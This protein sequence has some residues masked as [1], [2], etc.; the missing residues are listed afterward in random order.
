M[1]N[2]R[3]FLKQMTAATWLSSV[4]AHGGAPAVLGSSPAAKR[5]KARRRKRPVLWN[6]DGSDMLQPAYAGGKWPNPLKS[7]GKF[8]ANTLSYVKGTEVASIFYCAHVNEPDWEFPQEHIEVLGPNP[9]RHAVDFARQNGMEFFYSIRM[10]DIHASLFPPKASYWP[11]FRLKHPELMLGFISREHW[12]KKTLPWIQ[13]YS[14]IEKKQDLYD[15]QEIVELRRQAEEDHPLA[16]VIKRNGMASRDARFWAGYNYALPE[17]R[18]RYLEVV[19]GACRRYDLDGV[20]LD[21]C[22]HSMFFKLGEQR[23]NTPIMNDFVHQVRQTLDHFGERRGHPILLAVRPPDSIQLSLSAG[24]DPETW[25]RNHWVDLIIGGSG[26]MPYSIPIQEW[27]RLGHRYGIQ[28]YGCL[29]RLVQPFRTGRPKFDHRDPELEDDVAS[30][31]TAVDAASHRFWEEGVDGIYLFDWHTHHGPTDPKDYGTVPRVGDPKALVGKN[32]LYAIDPDRPSKTRNIPGQL[33]RV[34]TTQSGSNSV[35]FALTIVDE[36]DSVATATV[37]TQWKDATDGGR[38]T[39]KLNGRPISNP[40]P[41][42]P[43]GYISPETSRQYTEAGYGLG[44]QKEAGW[45]SFKVDPLTLRKGNNA[46]EL[47][48][49]PR[50]G[51][52]PSVPVELLQ[53]RVSLVSG[54]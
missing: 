32:K 5:A 49:D 15:P 22:R 12:E 14:E 34:L 10:N 13:R 2:R 20:E 1:K 16:D 37:L 36:P 24:L 41:S 30:D 43:K 40:Q 53:V 42:S 18:A 25:A 28:V 26:L 31:Y 44:F 54:A 21:W 50:R 19:E 29:D 48:V 17:V 51:G 23:R 38:A 11:P 4:S 45:L 35:R 39:W 47:T 8:L 3:T 52:E 9:V 27:V 6:N 33:P 7:P 46:L